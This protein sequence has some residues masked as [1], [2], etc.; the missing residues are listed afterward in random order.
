M[1]SRQPLHKGEKGGKAYLKLQCRLATLAQ[2]V[3]ISLVDGSEIPL[4]HDMS[5]NELADLLAETELSKVPLAENFVAC[6]AYISPIGSDHGRHL[7]CCWD[8]TTNIMEQSTKDS[9]LVGT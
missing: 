9:F 1:H 7:V 8:E 4:C 5:A 2:A 3:V 6:F